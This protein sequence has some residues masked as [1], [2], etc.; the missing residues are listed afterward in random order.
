MAWQ[1]LIKFIHTPRSLR[2]LFVLFFLL[3]S[4]LVLGLALYLFEKSKEETIYNLATKLT[5]ETSTRLATQINNELH[6]ATRINEINRDLAITFNEL[7][8]YNLMLQMALVELKNFPTISAFGVAQV[9]GASFRIS[10]YRDSANQFEVELLSPKQPNILQTFQVDS[11]GKR[12]SEIK[13]IK[14]FTLS[15]WAWYK[16][17]QKIQPHTWTQPYLTRDGAHLV[18]STFVPLNSSNPQQPDSPNSLFVSTISLKQ[19]NR[20]L[21]AQTFDVE[22]LALLVQPDGALIGSTIDENPYIAIPKPD[23]RSFTL[24][25][26]NLEES[27]SPLVASLSPL[28]TQAKTLQPGQSLQQQLQFQGQR[29]FVELERLNFDPSL[30]WLLITVVSEAEFS[31]AINTALTQTIILIVIVLGLLII[32]NLLVLQSVIRPIRRLQQH[33]TQLA[34]N[35][36]PHSSPLSPIKELQELNIAFHHMA[37]Q[38]QEMVAQLQTSNAELRE[39][40]NHLAQILDALPMGVAIYDQTKLVQ[41]INPTGLELFGLPETPPNPDVTT[42]NLDFHL[43]KAGLEQPYPLEELPGI[44]ALQGK[45]TE[46]EDLE[47]HIGATRRI[48][49]AYGI[50]IYNQAQAITAALFV[51]LDITERKQVEQILENYN[52]TLSKEVTERTLALQKSEERFRFALQSTDTSWWD[53]DVKTN[54]VAWSENFDQMVGR[55]PNSY[56]KNAASFLSFLHPDDVEPTRA[57]IID[58]VENN[59]PYKTEFRFVHPDGSIRWIMATGTVQRD[60]TGQAVRMSGIN[61]D[62]TE[63]KLAEEALKKSEE[64]LQLALSAET[65][66]WWKWDIVNDQMYSAP[67]FHD[68]L[69]RHGDELPQTWADAIAMIH[70]EDQAKVQAAMEATL[71]HDAPFKV[72]FRMMPANGKMVWIADLAALQRDETGRPLQLSGIMIDITERKQTEEALRISEERLRLSL[73]STGTSWWDWDVVNN[74]VQWSENFYPMVGRKPEECPPT[75]EGFTSLIHPDDREHVNQAIQASLEQDAP[76]KVEFRFLHP[77]GIVYWV[78]AKGIV[79]R[80]ETG[81]PIRMSGINLD[82]NERKQIEA[83]LQKSEQ[84]LRQTLE[85]TST[86]WWE[87]DLITNQSDWSENSDYTLGYTPDSYEKNQDTFLSLLHPEDRERVQKDMEAAIASGKPYQGEFR[88]IAADGTVQWIMGIGHC[89]YDHSGRPIRMSGLNINITPL[90]EV[91]LALAE[92]EQLLQALFDQASQFSALLTPSGQVVQINQRALDFAGVTEAD[93]QEQN[94]WDTPWW[95]RSEAIQEELKTAIYQ[96]SQGEI[97]R[98]DV[99]NCGKC[100]QQLVVDFSIRPIYDNNQAIR[101]LLCEGRDITDKFRIQQ[102]LKESEAR[103]RQT[104]Q[105]TAVSSALISLEGKFLEVNPAFC[106]LLGYH[107]DELKDHDLREVTDPNLSP[108]QADLTQQLLNR[109]I[110]AYTQ[111][112]CYQHRDGHWVWGLLNVS[113]VRDDYQHPLYFVCQIQNIDPLKQAQAELQQVNTELERLTQI[114]SLT[115]IFNRRYFDQALAQELQIASREGN[116]LSLLML[117]IDY[118]KNYNDTLGHQAGDQCLIK[119]TQTLQHAIHRTS[120]LVARYGGEEFALI[121][122]R[123][124][125]TGAIVIAQRIQ[126]LLAQKNLVHPTSEISSQITVSI[127]IHCATPRPGDHVYTWIKAA[128]DALYQAK[129]QGRNQYVISEQSSQVPS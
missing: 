67:S 9:Q 102:A 97:V 37:R 30:D 40:R 49:K 3:Q 8:D 81:R 66:N 93:V 2:A 75:V 100:G 17:I 15:D 32:F 117:D 96:A 78:M 80:D 10:R 20:L 19:I 94:F 126:N 105:T 114:D 83:D 50:P 4:G 43:F 95:Q 79:Q 120:D 77:D 109:E 11:N 7:F 65:A 74:S 110:T 27:Q 14:P 101:Y 62:I 123:T 42:F 59:T 121:L 128:D 88:L 90:K 119:V 29:Y 103:F 125:L 57:K 58:A 35:Q 12:L 127:G 112:R 91:E 124:E 76:Y 87:R 22:A 45:P 41:Y 92:R 44:Q 115:G 38:I 63:R 84:R 34:T 6:T 89:E 129:Q 26:L 47:V 54:E 31:Q 104:F 107:P 98:Y 106:D 71:D 51:F 86:N 33:I 68:L 52:A 16:S 60:E 55:A 36:F 25:R 72:E 39:Q 82:I 48:L 1:T 13:P 23:Q 85:S 5:T 56:P 24:K 99:V 18:I 70:P 53:W 118:F 69:G 113:L 64:S 108:F 116:F 46:I 61:L 122:P 21:E 111:E 28:L 73:S